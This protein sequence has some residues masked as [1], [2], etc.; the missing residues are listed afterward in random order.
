VEYLVET[1]G[2]GDLERILER[3]AAGGSTEQALKEVL[4]DDYGD[5]M[6][7]TVEYLKKNYAK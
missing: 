7:S 2:I 6:R 5:L 4:R 1:Q 3:I